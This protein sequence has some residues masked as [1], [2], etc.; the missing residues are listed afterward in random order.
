[1]SFQRS[2]TKDTV[3]EVRYQGNR[4]YKA[5][6]GEN[7]NANNVYETGWLN[8]EFELAQANL[9][10]NV[11]AGRGPS[12]AYMG[13]GTGTA[14]LPIMLAHL[15]ASTD[16]NNAG[17]Y[18][19]GVWTNSTLT[20]Y[21]DPY[22][23]NPSSFA[24]TLYGSTF[25]SSLMASGVSTRLFNNAIAVGYP[26]N[27]WRLNPMLSGVNV[28]TNTDNK[29]LNHLVTL[30]LRRRLAAGLSAQVGYTWQRNIS[31][32][33]LDYHLPRLYLETTGV[34]HAIQTLWSYDI[35][36]GRGKRY[37]ANMNAWLDGVVGGWTFS[38]SARFQTQSFFI[39]DAKLVGMTQAEA[40][41]DLSV[42]RFVTDPVTGV[43]TV[44]NFPEDIYT[45]TRLAYATDETQ[46]N[47]YAPGTEPDGPLAMP[48][49]NGTYRYF[50]PA[51][52]PDCNFIYTGDCGTQTLRFLGRWFGEMDFRLAKSFQLPGRARF[53]FSAEIFNATKALNFP[54]TIN[55]STSSNAFRMTSTQSPA[56]T[57]QLVWRVS[58]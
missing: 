53:E 3:V 27:Y 31:G 58:W 43:V 49:A 2:V 13:P 56:R 25:S 30:Q 9:H 39:R 4:S 21:L 54:N 51:G 16:V 14:P 32:S 42:I 40:Q 12:I 19:G 28:Y 10:A 7:W 38:G 37:G 26:T 29:P 24:S 41:R 33:L 11:V 57:A 17:A 52:G 46:A 45:N 1:M 15:N 18:A 44:F 48:T 36:V 6:S 23:P 34:P 8:G 5:W 47:Y 22:F 35:P 20:G 55:P 50:A